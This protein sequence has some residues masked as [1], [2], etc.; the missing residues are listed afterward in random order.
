MRDY[1]NMP[2]DTDEDHLFLSTGG[3][4]ASSDQSNLPTISQ[5]FERIRVL[6]S[7]CG[8]AGST[9]PLDGLS[10]SSSSSSFSMNLLNGKAQL[11]NALKADLNR[12]YSILL[13]YVISSGLEGFKS[14]TNGIFTFSIELTIIN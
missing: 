10:A 5:I 7:S 12:P 11:V 6:I 8:S 2:F 9:A 13:K 14:G 1:I 3:K 4:G